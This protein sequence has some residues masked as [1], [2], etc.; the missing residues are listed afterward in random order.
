MVPKSALWEISNTAEFSDREA[1]R[2]LTNDT[3]QNLSV[4]F[5]TDK[6]SNPNL[7]L[8]CLCSD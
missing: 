2:K 6:A 8:T 4:A 3:E 5:K 1:V 7:S